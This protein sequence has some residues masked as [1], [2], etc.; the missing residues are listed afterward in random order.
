MNIL[1]QAAAGASEYLFGY[2]LNLIKMV[3]VNHLH[4][5]K[6]SLSVDMKQEITQGE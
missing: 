1:D 2:D 3:T 5:M 4:R 6:Q